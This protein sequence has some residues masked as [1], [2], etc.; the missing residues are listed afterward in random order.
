M[1]S[2]QHGLDPFIQFLEDFRHDSHLVYSTL[3]Q[4]GVDKTNFGGQVLFCASQAS[5]D[6]VKSLLVSRTFEDLVKVVLDL[7]LVE[8]GL[9][10]SEKLMEGLRRVVYVFDGNLDVWRLHGWLA[11]DEF[12]QA[13]GPGHLPGVALEKLG[14]AI[15]FGL[16]VLDLDDDIIDRTQETNSACGNADDLGLIAS[17]LVGV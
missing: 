4:S 13:L 7:A 6:F 3:N 12:E 9:L 16:C 10:G 15:D 14:E 5:H 1:I 11:S 8:R 2:S 17:W